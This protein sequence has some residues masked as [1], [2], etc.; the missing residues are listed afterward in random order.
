MR[1]VTTETLRHGEKQRIN[2]SG[3]RTTSGCP[4]SRFFPVSPRLRREA[5][6]AVVQAVHR[7][8]RTGL[9]VV[10]EIFDESAYARFLS[11]TGNVRSAASYR[12]FLCDREAAVAGRPR[13][14]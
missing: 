6:S 11:R 8:A 5:Y 2:L 4:V 3:Y 14:C 12:Q 13:C 1:D 7:A 9:A 10:R